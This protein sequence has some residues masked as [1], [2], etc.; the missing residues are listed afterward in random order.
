MVTDG[1]LGWVAFE[2]VKDISD[3]L[4]NVAVGHAVGAQVRKVQVKTE[5]PLEQSQ[6]RGLLL[7][8]NKYIDMLSLRTIWQKRLPV[9]FKFRLVLLPLVLIDN[10][11]FSSSSDRRDINNDPAVQF[12]ITVKEFRINSFVK[13]GAQLAW[14]AW[15]L[16]TYPDRATGDKLYPSIPSAEQEPTTGFSEYIESTKISNITQDDIEDVLSLSDSE[17]LAIN[18]LNKRFSKI[19][20]DVNAPFPQTIKVQIPQDRYYADSFNNV[21]NIPEEYIDFARSNKYDDYYAFP[22]FNSFKINTLELTISPKY[23]GD[24]KYYTFILKIDGA[25]AFEQKIVINEIYNV[26]SYQFTFNQININ[27]D[28]IQPEDQESKELGTIIEGGIRPK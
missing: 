13:A 19:P 20:F 2:I 23:C 27:D 12:V 24:N 10:V 14:L 22:I 17:L 18:I 15:T 3:A 26:N 8:S 6:F 25:T 5:L 7:G 1:R 9:P 16:A 4:G 21:N 28:N 11:T